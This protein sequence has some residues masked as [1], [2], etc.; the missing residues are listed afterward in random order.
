MITQR[1]KYFVTLAKLKNYTK[2]AQELYISQPALSKQIV[3]LEEDLGVKLF[4]RNTKQVRLTFAGEVLFEQAK[5]L[6]AQE[7]NIRHQLNIASKVEKVNLIIGNST[8]WGT[9]HLPYVFNRLIIEYP[10][11]SISLRQYNYS[12]ILQNLSRKLINIAIVRVSDLTLLQN[13]D[14]RVIHS[15]GLAAFTNSSHRFARTDTIH[16]R[17]LV[18]ETFVQLKE[19]MSAPFINAMTQV[20]I[21]TGCVPNIAFEYDN[22]ESVFFML[23]TA[24]YVALLSDDIKA[25]GLHTAAIVDS[26]PIFL[27]AVWNKNDNDPYIKNFLDAMV[28]E[29]SD[30]TL[31]DRTA[32]N[33]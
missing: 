12:V 8:G 1:L 16:F 13:Y 28:G 7:E 30:N 33:N 5:L 32:E 10:N 4:D 15:S 27:C 18:N 11:V 19:S 31:S 22:I 25:E 14:Y 24:R 29:V 2:A 20:T 3:S 26:Q 6:I 23:R 21:K 9:Y 17:D